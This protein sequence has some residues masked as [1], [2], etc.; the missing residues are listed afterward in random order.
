[1]AFRAPVLASLFLIVALATL[2]MPG[3]SN[4]A[5][6]FLILLGTFRAKLPI[7]VI[8]FAGVVG[9]AFYALRIYIGAMHNRVGPKVAAREIGVSEFVPVAAV[10]LVILVFAFYPQ[11]G[12][13]RSEPTV[14]AT[15]AQYASPTPLASS[16]ITTA[17]R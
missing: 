9:A 10:T 12:L 4:F 14:S 6:E 5:G 2:A 16:P 11:F 1:M 7:A 15:V 13:K 17:S 3:S 8:A